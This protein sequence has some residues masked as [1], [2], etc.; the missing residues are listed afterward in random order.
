MLFAATARFIPSEA[1]EH[2]LPQ[3][4]AINAQILQGATQ[5]NQNAAADR[6]RYESTF[7]PMENQY[8]SRP[9]N[10]D[11]PAREQAQAGAAEATVAQQTE[12][13]RQAAA[14]A[15]E[16]YGVDPSSTRYAALDI[17][18]RT[19]QAAAMAAAGNNAVNQTQF[20]KVWRF[21]RTR[22]TWEG[23]PCAINSWVQF[24]NENAGNSA[25][26]NTNSTTSTGFGA[27]GTGAQWG[28]L[29]NSALGNL[30]STLGAS[31]RPSNGKLVRALDGVQFWDCW[32]GRF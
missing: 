19:G 9:Q 7:I 25:V 30:N 27:M 16:S 3:T 29:A 5:Q 10:W 1:Y 4:D 26:G 13:A 23:A 31:T 22:S 14:T 12:A 21:A 20:K 32:A 24:S 11:T 6:A 18:T 8:A 2:S 28:G 17:G 15:L